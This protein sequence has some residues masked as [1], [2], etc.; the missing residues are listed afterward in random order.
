MNWMSILVG[1]SGCGKNSIVRVL[2][3]LAGQK[4]KSIVVNSAMDTTEILGGFEQTD[5]NRHLEQVVER[6]ENLLID[7]FKKQMRKEN[8][9]RI[10]KYQALIERVRK[11]SHDE[12]ESVTMSLATKV[13][14]YKID[15]L[16]EL[17]EE[18][19][20]FDSDI[21]MEIEAIEFNLHKLKQLVQQENCLN[22]GGKFEWIDSI[23]VK[24]LQDGT[25]LLVDQVNLCS[26]AVLDRLNGLLEPNGSLSIGE[27]GVDSDG[28][29]VTIEPHKNFKLF[30]TMDPKYGEISRAM[31]N[32]GV[33]IFMLN[34]NDNPETGQLDYRS[35]LHYSG[36]VKKNHHEALLTIHARISKDPS[37][38]DGLNIVQLLH[39]AFLIVQ[40]LSRGFPALQA[41]KSACMD[42]YLKA[43]LIFH[44][45]TRTR[46][47]AIIDD[48]VQQFHVD[49]SEE[50]AL[51]LDTATCSLRNLLDN[52]KLILLKQ[53]GIILD[54][55]TK[56][57]MS[58][59][60]KEISLKTDFI[61]EFLAL[62]DEESPILNV[63]VL[64]ILPYVLLNFYE[65]SS[66]SDVT[67]R[68]VWSSNIFKKYS[69]F[70][71]LD[72]KNSMLVEEMLSFDFE[73]CD[74]ERPWDRKQFKHSNNLALL[75]YYVSLIVDNEIKNEWKISNRDE[76]ITVAQFSQAHLEGKMTIKLKDQCLITNYVTFL[77]Q[78]Q[79]YIE[80]ILRKSRRIIDEFSYVILRQNLKWFSRFCHLGKMILVDKSKKSNNQFENLDEVVLLIKVHYKW[81]K[82]C[83]MHLGEYYN[84]LTPTDQDDY[85]K[86]IID[87]I[88]ESIISL[89]DPFRKIC[90]IY[91]KHIIS[92]LPH[93]SDIVLK[94]HT[95]LQNVT[96]SFYP[97]KNKYIST[98]LIDEQK[99]VALQTEKA[100]MIRSEL[101]SLWQK[102]YSNETINENV[103]RV[104]Q[105]TSTFCETHL[106]I[107]VSS[108]D[109]TST[110][111]LQIQLTNEMAKTAA[112]IQLWPL[113]EYMFIL[114]VG[115]VQ[116]KFCQNL[117]KELNDIA[118]PSSCL[119][120][121]HNNIPNIPIELHGI[122]STI[123]EKQHNV[124]ERNRLI[125]A[126]FVLF[127]KFSE[128]SYA[129]KSFQQITH[130]QNTTVQGKGKLNGST[131]M[132]DRENLDS[133]PIL[134]TLV[135]ELLF[136]KSQKLYSEKSSIIRNV[137][138]GNHENRLEQLK[139]LNDLLWKN[140]VAINSQQFDAAFND[141]QTLYHLIQN[142][143]ATSAM[144]END[145][146]F[147]EL[148]YKQILSCAAALAITDE[149]LMPLSN[150]RR[151]SKLSLSELKL[152][153]G[154]AWALLGYLHT[155]IFGNMGYI[156]PVHKVAL[157]LNYVQEDITDCEKTIYVATLYS[158]I[159]GQMDN[160]TT[161]PRI[162]HMQDSLTSLKIKRESLSNLKAVRPKNTEFIALSK[163]FINFRITLGSYTVVNKHIQQLSDA[164]IKL[165]N[166]LNVNNIENLNSSIREAEIWLESMHRF[167]DKIETR[168][169]TGYPDIVL[170]ILSGLA[171]MRHG[172]RILK[173]E[174]CKEIAAAERNIDSKKL[175]GF[176]Q[177]LMRF[178]TIGPEQE[179]LL[180]LVNLC[181]SHESRILLSNSMKSENTFVILHEQFKLTIA[182]LYEFYNYI[183][184]RGSLT[185]P[186]WTQLNSILH[187]ISL[188]WQQ[189][190]RE[191]EK[192]EAEQGSL[193]KNESK[194]RGQTLTEE[195]EILQ[196]LKD[197]FPTQR[198]TDF[199]DIHN[200]LTP[201]LEE[202]I[203]VSSE[204]KDFEA[205]IGENDMQEVQNIHSS[206][207]KTFA[208][209][210]WLCKSEDGMRPDFIEPFLQR[211]GTFGLLLFN[212]L[213]A[214]TNT[215]TA[216]LYTSLNVL[217]CTASRLGLGEMLSP[218]GSLNVVRS[219]DKHY[220]YYKDSNIE[221]V[222][223]CVPLLKS[224]S[225]KILE[226]LEQWPEHPTLI[227]LRII[228]ERID[229]FPV[230]SAVSR[231]L[232]GLE[233]LLVKMHEW[234]ENAHSDVTLTEFILALTQQIIAWRKL[235]LACWKDCLA[236]TQLRLRSRTS[237][238]WFYLYALFDSYVAKSEDNAD[239]DPITSKKLI[240]S[241][242]L[243]MNSSTLVEFEARLELV[244]TF[245]CHAYYLNP[246][247]ERDN[248]L[249]ISWNIY[250][251]YKQFLSDVNVKINLIK[252]PI[253]K[254]LKDFVKIA[255]WN[256]ISYWAVKE[257]IEKTHRTLHKF[258][259]EFENGLKEPVTPQ[260]IVKPSYKKDTGIWDRVENSR[261][262][263]INP[264]D[265]IINASK[266]KANDISS[267]K[268][269]LIARADTHYLLR[270]RKLCKEVILM[271]SYP[272]LRVTFE[273]FVEEFTNHGNSLRALE[274][275]RTLPKSKQ[276]SQA[277]SILQQ[278]RLALADYFKA[279]MDFGV[280]HRIG[281]LAWKNKLD[282]VIDYT[283]PPLD[284]K[285]ALK[286]IH[287]D[288]NG[289]KILDQWDGIE[290]YYY[291][292]LIKLNALN[293]T[294]LT[295]KTDLGNQN[296]E[297]CMGF[298]TH[299]MLMAN[300]QKKILAAAFKYLGNLDSHI[301]DLSSIS[302][303]DT[304]IRKQVDLYNMANNLKE[305]LI[306]A[307]TSLEQFQ[308]Y[309]QA[310]PS[311]AQDAS[312][313]NTYNLATNDLAIVSCKKGDTIWEKAN[314]YIVECLKLIIDIVKKFD[315][316]FPEQR[317]I[318]GDNYE[319]E[320]QT[321]IMT[322]KHFEF[323]KESFIS[324]T[325]VKE[326]LRHFAIMFYV[327]EK[328]HPLLT[329]IIFLETNITRILN[330]FDEIMISSEQQTIS[331][332]SSY[333]DD[334]DKYEINL[335]KLLNTV[336]F[337]IQDKYKNSLP[338]EIEFNYKNSHSNENLNEDPN[339]DEYER[340]KLKE[341]LIESIEA[342][343]K[344]LKLKEIYQT[345]N[346]LLANIFY[347]NS[348][349]I[350][351]YCGLLKKCLP[352]LHQY[353]LLVQFYLNEQV[354]ALRITC[355][356][357]HMQL[358]VFLDLA[359]NGFCVPKDL[360]LEEG[361][362][363]SE[364]SSKGGMGLGDGEGQTD[365]SDRIETEDQLEDARPAG[366]EKEK[367]EDKDCPEE[368]K[369]IEMS[370]DFE[371]KLQDLDKKE[372][373]DTSNND[374]KDDENID[375]EM[376]DT[377]GA[378]DK[379][380]QQIWGD[381]EDELKNE[382]TNKDKE[383]IGDGESTGDKEFGNK[384]DKT[385]ESPED[386]GND[387]NEINTEQ[388]KEINEMEEP[389]YDEDHVNPYHGKHQPE[390]EPEPLDL[391]EDINMEDDNVE[392]DEQNN[393][394]NP[395][396]ID[397]MKESIEVPENQESNIPENEEINDEIK[398]THTD[399]SDEEDE[400]EK[401]KSTD[402]PED[403]AN[404]VDE[405]VDEA[406]QQ[407][408]EI[409]KENKEE[410][411][412]EGVENEMEEKAMPSTDEPS[413]ELDAS[414]QVNETE[415]GSKDNVANGVKNEQDSKEESNAENWQ[416]ERKDKGTGQ[417][418]AEEHNSGHSGTSLEKINSVSNQDID[419]QQNEKRKHPGK[420]DE[421]HMLAEK[422]EPDK[423]KLKTMIHSQEKL[424]EDGNNDEGAERDENGEPD[425]CQHVK[426]KEK[427]D[428]YAMDAATE[429]Q[430]KEQASNKEEEDEAKD[431]AQAMDVDM[432]EDE[433]I[434]IVDDES[435]LKQ[436]PEKLLTDNKP[437]DKKD[438][439]EKG[440]MQDGQLETIVGV[441]G[442][443]KETMKIT[444]GIESNFF[445]NMSEIES[446][447]LSTKLIEDKRIEVEKMLSEWR[448]VPTTEEATV[449]WNTLSAITDTPA[450]DLS[451]KLRL[452]LEPTQASRLKGDYRT[453]KRI[454]MRKIIPYVASQFRKDKIWLRRTKP[455]KRNYQIVL[456]IDDSSSMA[457]NH[458][459]ELAFE[460]L[461]LISK[462]MTYLEAGQLSVISFGEE[463]SILHALGEPFS[464]RSGSRL[465]QEISF[466]QK[467]TIVAKL[468]D[469]TVDMFQSQS[470][471]MDNAK[472]LLILSDG[473][474]VFS[475]GMDRINRA[476]HRARL[477]DIF[478]VFIIV[479]GPLNKDSI[480]DIR[481]PMFKDGN[482]TG[483]N[484]YMD[485]FPFPFYMILR[486]INALPGVLS[487]ALRQWF[488]V[489]GKIDS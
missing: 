332:V 342:D 323:L 378:V 340:N 223:Q 412:M 420:S 426:E 205:L 236:T 145:S 92:P 65:H 333:K 449:A 246:S 130:W 356:I 13:F 234:E 200:V 436:D 188:I 480:L 440:R 444:R 134:V 268:S 101:I 213:P 50:Y 76:I 89:Y 251:Y 292:S 317:I 481:I 438:K 289:R 365:V 56:A 368:D 235:E 372:E 99:F 219:N 98:N 367:L 167:M 265:Y 46:L 226:L 201:S 410:E 43:R 117:S 45:E 308:I 71:L 472:L 283:I 197:L 199:A 106:N 17:L 254:K 375:K 12:C 161:H 49:E 488:E 75:L 59:N 47:S 131:E 144:V 315:I 364:Q 428:H 262:C 237:K 484:S 385:Q 358:N 391:S 271:S 408:S 164:T 53:Q 136:D 204:E 331:D 396:D 88:D 5:Y 328:N 217:S 296:M 122:L 380:D 24:C 476:V 383:E 244:L 384:D 146:R 182:G 402:K 453:G 72:K 232:T 312:D 359:T 281:I 307:Q 432:H 33:E 157:K 330:K 142:F 370:E 301:S 44:Y 158:R 457:D 326:N 311:E 118:L 86:N 274:V 299:L 341:K 42:V 462:A 381:D 418:K 143:L 180:S 259:K 70:D 80:N 187:Q 132:S 140:S 69:K 27:R 21:S 261:N 108:E 230:T 48:T 451:E 127:S 31:R 429:K 349:L 210:E 327:E 304:L 357:L 238:W 60:D 196:E 298:S 269:D 241:L 202:K 297:R 257:T 345:L 338:S 309:L 19:K 423:K 374:D 475:E 189:Q 409:N 93:S 461:S 1:G 479:D 369:G 215:P 225:G 183:V 477:A 227:S 91:K 37:N 3:Q 4:L 32:R 249:A 233:L 252:T 163:E 62:H 186:L 229:S 207:V 294:L 247:T 78:F 348:E 166:E 371:G 184:L 135:A 121:H 231:F 467:K 431:D 74:T 314:C 116:R 464:E 218:G 41:F 194:V 430:S 360:D 482:L 291:G 38:V 64:D 162:H 192:R 325:S 26:P 450:R 270:A 148:F 404:K 111:Q 394:E 29:V 377:T 153:R 174:S 25:W 454:N 138:L 81:L 279:L 324:L 105:D 103:F 149:Y 263:D 185:K 28:N 214:L 171:Q 248:L 133:G 446:D 203:K 353:L 489:V 266:K 322:T 150:L 243:F 224:I 300:K 40:Q 195:E 362:E 198:E 250:N 96:N 434:E 55:C 455:S 2:A 346:H 366:Q 452:V 95:M 339:D 109:S 305:L 416:D 456:A 7:C 437:K 336:L 125:F 82:K 463:L 206:I 159:L 67:L 30:L 177:G 379:L 6:T 128:H 392:N 51:N 389:E 152:K 351:Y 107:T 212:V 465:M 355:K 320:V 66:L 170:P 401:E 435:T 10:E 253:E 123:C 474:G 79:N 347:S 448:Q 487:D 18:I 313:D 16:V 403:E 344:A 443:I 90:K 424:S 168:F 422:I 469:F 23:L 399:T 58:H 439:N 141:L 302:I 222:K 470:N 175:E 334:C 376:D 382:Q 260:L 154:E 478:L 386:Q 316:M 272:N 151:I 425:M 137:A 126:L 20:Y 398:D 181:I 209:S 176:L 285:A 293:R 120:V 179:S 280:S 329:N 190:Q 352:L 211:C 287:L 407:A 415:D 343:I 321:R 427:F 54:W 335:E 113:H 155:F 473:R 14:L 77:L 35:L 290:R 310:C 442:E 459:K 387:K 73:D 303:D 319:S 22:A 87:K 63:Q 245:H 220:D 390:P 110:E 486:D 256:D 273:D 39:S 397:K 288:G 139:T 295:S 414:K 112:K 286:S 84:D 337:V 419:A 97:S 240:E 52:S 94:A 57:Y 373:D 173:N 115:M 458:S 208:D 406:I 361:E 400:T 276:K 216:N 114:F 278:K 483:I 124:V 83:L 191:L 275:D 147:K 258:I 460:S 255:R 36:L 421:T 441:E 282:E 228:L 466:K 239:N 172:I 267:I 413:K 363:G 417:S 433:E 156:D 485:S 165:K 395:F 119:S 178:P 34:C 61:N 405:N 242:E 100:L 160:C 15:S 85:L 411:N 445:T 9:L 193:Y 318:Y 277:K 221:E 393:E 468:V 447:L 169:M 102:I 8:I 129:I 350:S 388:Q 306:T 284:V 11:L 354:A 68:R 264:N 104:L 471:S